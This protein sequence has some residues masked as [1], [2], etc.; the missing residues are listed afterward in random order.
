MTT[1]PAEG[2]QWSGQED[3]LP[4]VSGLDRRD[5]PGHV[6]GERGGDDPHGEDRDADRREEGGDRACPS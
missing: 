6:Q 5:L 4:L 1:A 3:A 2:E